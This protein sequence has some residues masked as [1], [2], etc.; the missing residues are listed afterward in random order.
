MN[1]EYKVIKHDNNLHELAIE[2][3][4]RQVNFKY[5]L[6]SD[7]H[8]D[9]PKCKRKILKAHLDQAK[10]EEV[11][12]IIN[13]DF[14]CV[15]QG[16]YDK[17]ASKSDIRPQH[18]GKNYIDLVIEEAV[19]WFS[20][21]AEILTLIGYGNHETSLN[22]R[23]EFDILKNFQVR[24]N[25]ANPNQQNK[26]EIGGYGGY[27]I[28]SNQHTNHIIRYHHGHGGGGAVTK[29]TIQHNR[30]N[31]FLSNVDCIW[32]G[33]VHEDYELT[34]IEE[35]I[36][37]QKRKHSFKEV[38]NIRT[39]TYKEEFNFGKGGWHVERGAF[40]KP[41]GGRWLNLDFY[42]DKIER[43]VKQYT[44][45]TSDRLNHFEDSNFD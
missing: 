36:S 34:T 17:R 33:H 4:S 12:V 13:G 22:K 18:N 27:L 39:S 23:L 2:T 41:L 25:H 19:E 44:T 40:P 3:H 14:F 9:N 7:L 26:L 1:M 8:F 31:A 24:F 6:L 42:R 20:P 38:L 45:K 28:T 21:Y 5:L 30:F 16:K 43:F 32:M 29:G 37:L 35:T 11:P 10:K 15:M